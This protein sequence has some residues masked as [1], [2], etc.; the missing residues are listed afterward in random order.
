MH[1]VRVTAVFFRNPVV[2]EGFSFTLN[3]LQEAPVQQCQYLIQSQYLDYQIVSKNLAASVIKAKS[4]L[5]TK[6]LIFSS[7]VPTVVSSSNFKSTVSLPSNSELFCFKVLNLS[8]SKENA[9][10][11]Y[12]DT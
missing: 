2:I 5:K 3:H 7:T 11:S 10:H 9:L 1:H 6:F 12:I 4:S 8:F